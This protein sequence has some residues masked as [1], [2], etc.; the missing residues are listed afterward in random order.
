MGCEAAN[1]HLGSKYGIKR[2]LKDLRA[3]EPNWLRSPAKEMA[4]AVTTLEGIRWRV[5]QAKCTCLS[6]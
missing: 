2:V 6:L 4:K 3:R 5:F 1:V